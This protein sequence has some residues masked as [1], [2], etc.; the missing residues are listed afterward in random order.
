VKRRQLVI[1]VVLATL[2]LSAF[3]VNA[4]QGAVSDCSNTVRGAPGDGTSG[5]VWA[6]WAWEQT[7]RGLFAPT[8]TLTGAGRGDPLWAPTQIV[9]VAWSVPMRVLS[10]V[11]NPVCG[12]NLTIAFGYVFSGLSMFALVYALTNSGNAALFS[13][14]AFAFSSFALVKGEGHVSGVYLGLFAL[15]ILA[16]LRLWVRP[17][18]WRIGIVGLVWALLPYTDGYY[19]AFSIVLVAAFTAG[20]CVVEIA[21]KSP[22]NAVLQRLRAVAVASLAALVLLLPYATIL[23]RNRGAISAERS[24]S[25]EDV[26]AS[27][28]RLFEFVVPPYGNP[29][30]PD[31]FDQ[32]RIDRL[33][34][35]NFTESSIY[36]G[37]TVLILAGIA[38]A[39]AAT[40]RLRLRNNWPRTAAGAPP[41]V[42]TVVSLVAIAFA[43]VLVSLPPTLH[44]LGASLPMPSRFVHAVFPEMR[45]MSRAVVIVLAALVALAGLAIAHL[46]RRIRRPPVRVLTTAAL[47]LFA[48]AET[49]TFLPGQAPQWSFSQTPRVYSDLARDRSV[50]TVALYPMSTTAEDPDLLYLTFQPIMKKTLVNSIADTPSPT[51]PSDIARGLASLADPATVPVLRSLGTDR[52]L[53]ERDVLG[54]PDPA[55][56]ERLGLTL[57]RAYHYKLDDASR[58]KNGGAGRWA[59]LA[60]Y[61]NI[62]LYKIDPGTPAPVAIALGDGWFDFEPSGW[63]GHRWMSKSAQFTVVPLRPARGDARVSFVASALGSKRRLNITADGRP[64][65]SYL[66]PG[67]GRTVTFRAPIGRT[68]EFRT[69]PGRTPADVIPGSTDTRQVTISISGLTIGSRCAVIANSTQSAC[70]GGS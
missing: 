57:M 66:I 5:G 36:V 40:R 54:S 20:A 10:D 4:M 69:R 70:T 14:V 61:S 65:A 44:F 52:I 48:T 58:Q 55:L 7:D 63:G 64:L 62:D 3:T 34:G 46:L 41:V 38:I 33:H 24:R 28:A 68:L 8:Q 60:K 30:M 1:W 13:A 49:L 11:T 25:L 15:L 39:L 32:W 53:V 17:N 50:D 35:S 21:H 12:Y 43:G 26:A 6:N 22:W 45:V 47:I 37:W 9:N 2:V 29:F 19:L 18:R 16:L 56:L 67:T 27:S 31:G 23:L 42:V 51:D 59:Y